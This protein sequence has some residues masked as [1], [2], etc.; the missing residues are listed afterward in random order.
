MIGSGKKEA[1]EEGGGVG[2]VGGG[3]GGEG[4]LTNRKSLSSIKGA[5]T[6]RGGYHCSKSQHDVQRC[7]A[8]SAHFERR[9]KNSHKTVPLNLI[10]CKSFVP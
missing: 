2:G 6:E 1:E 3:G 4:L 9:P 5:L 8:S 10:I 7:L